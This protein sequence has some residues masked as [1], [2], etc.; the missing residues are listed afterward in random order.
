MPDDIASVG[1]PIVPELLEKRGVAPGVLEGTVKIYGDPSPLWMRMEIATTETDDYFI[2]IMRN[3]SGV[4]IMVDLYRKN[5]DGTKG[6]RLR[7]ITFSEMVLLQHLSWLAVDSA[8][9]IDT[10][11]E[12]EVST[13]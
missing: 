3:F 10:P 6:A 2:Q 12:E 7:T 11:A 5:P 13:P 1:T 9:K 4:G 8:N